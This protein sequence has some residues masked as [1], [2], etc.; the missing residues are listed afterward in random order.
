MAIGVMVGLIEFTP[1]SVR[2]MVPVEAHSIHV[3]QKV[4][5]TPVLLSAA[6]VPEHPLAGGRRRPTSSVCSKDR[7]PGRVTDR[8]PDH[9]V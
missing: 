3:C 9:A 8:K 2:T 1:L 6:Y 7:P 4:A 5:P